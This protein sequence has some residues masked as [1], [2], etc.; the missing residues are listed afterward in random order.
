MKLSFAAPLLI[1][2]ACST[3]PP[4]AGRSDTLFTRVHYGDSR[5]A[6]EAVLGTPDRRMRFP[7]SGNEG[8]DYD[9][10]DSWGYMAVYS[11][12]FSPAGQVVGTLSNRINSGGDM[13]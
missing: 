11:V 10:Q 2:V 4:Q 12:T 7:N 5:A 6:V 3:V 13:H 8:W 9:Y 1:A